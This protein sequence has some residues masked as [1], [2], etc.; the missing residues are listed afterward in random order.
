MIGFHE[1]SYRVINNIESTILVSHGNGMEIKLYKLPIRVMFMLTCVWQH[2]KYGSKLM[3]D[4]RIYICKIDEESGGI[5]FAEY[6]YHTIAYT[7]GIKLAS[8]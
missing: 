2:W 5:G 8:M 1:L 7:T 3:Y 4:Q 6:T